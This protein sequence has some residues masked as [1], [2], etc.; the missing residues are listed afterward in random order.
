MAAL[1]LLACCVYKLSAVLKV[2]GVRTAFLEGAELYDVARREEDFYGPGEL[3]ATHQSHSGRP[4]NP[5]ASCC[6]TAVGAACLL[7]AF[8]VHPAPQ[9][10]FV[11][12]YARTRTRCPKGT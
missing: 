4:S 11:E 5:F 3:V 10:G 6:R 1:V 8:A 9:L 2:A 12:H 7:G